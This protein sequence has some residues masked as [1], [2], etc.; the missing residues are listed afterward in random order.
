[1]NERESYLT[2]NVWVILKIQKKLFE[3]S[4][5]KEDLVL[6]LYAVDIALLDTLG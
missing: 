5:L 3:N 2:L 6:I 1:M 4:L